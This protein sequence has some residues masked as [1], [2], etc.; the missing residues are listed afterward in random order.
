MMSSVQPNNRESAWT[1]GVFL[2]R[3]AFTRGPPVAPAPAGR[4]ADALVSSEEFTGT[5][6]KPSNRNFAAADSQ[7]K[8]KGALPG[9]FSDQPGHSDNWR[10]GGQKA[11]N[12]RQSELATPSPSTDNATSGSSLAAWIYTK[13]RD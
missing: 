6:E 7:A 13:P 4:P 1:T 11:V 12:R 2:C 9:P 5:F 8:P 10:H 3:E